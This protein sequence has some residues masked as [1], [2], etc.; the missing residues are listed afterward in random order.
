MNVALN[1][2]TQSNAQGS[3]NREQ[4]QHRWVVDAAL[5]P[6]YDIGMNSRPPCQRRLTQ[7]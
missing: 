6:A 3:R 1:Q 4:L 7:G 5:E 2:V